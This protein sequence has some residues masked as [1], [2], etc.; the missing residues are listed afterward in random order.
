MRLQAG[1][2]LFDLVKHI[3]FCFSLEGDESTLCSFLG[4]ILTLLFHIYLCLNICIALNLHLVVLLSRSP[5]RRWEVWYW[6][7]SL[8]LPLGL[9]LP[10]LGTA[11]LYKSNFQVAGRFGNGGGVCLIREETRVDDILMIV[12]WSVVSLATI[13]YCLVVSILVAGKTRMKYLSKVGISDEAVV[14]FRSVVCWT[15]LYPIAC[16]ISCVG[17]NINVIYYYSFGHVP[18]WLSDLPLIGISTVGILNLVA[19]LADPKVF[20]AL[21]ALCLPPA[22]NPEFDDPYL[23][24]L[25]LAGEFSYNRLTTDD[26]GP[27]P[28]RRI[29]KEFQTF[30]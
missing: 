1:I 28:R 4:F 20:R 26:G 7:V 15:C 14:S 30:I 9:N 5:S 29:L 19:F 12:Y 24:D 2:A 21:P 3:L 18:Q 6:L 25:S 22:A 8:A 10:P 27:V 13:L 23:P 16:F 17:A 11:P